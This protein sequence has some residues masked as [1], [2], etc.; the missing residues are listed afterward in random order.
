M[1]GIIKHVVRWDLVSQKRKN[2]KGG[3]GITGGGIKGKGKGKGGN[4]GIGVSAGY[5]AETKSVLFL[6]EATLSTSIA[7]QIAGV[8]WTN[9]NNIM[10]DTYAKVGSTSLRLYNSGNTRSTDIPD[11]GTGDF[12]VG[13]WFYGG[14]NA[15]YKFNFDTHQVGAG[16]TPTGFG[17]YTY[18]NSGLV[19]FYTGATDNI[20]GTTNTRDSAWHY[21]A[22]S[23]VSG[24]TRLFVDGVQEGSS[25]TDTN[26]YAFGA[27]GFTW[28]YPAYLS[29]GAYGFDG[30]MDTAC[31]V[32]GAGLSTTFTPPLDG[33][34]P[35][36][37]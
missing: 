34:P 4:P 36:G 14:N 21:I 3:G 23:R 22:V 31:I 9:S 1:S 5:S 27:N 30:W 10:D 33:N 6:D 11:F 25:Y 20:V 26:D 12:F 17:V 24:V 37:L 18:N 16:S 28:G 29:A 7:D 35:A 8:T 15:A 32:V 19:R 13:A 2:G